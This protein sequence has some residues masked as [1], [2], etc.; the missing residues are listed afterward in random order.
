MLVDFY[1]NQTMADELTNC[2]GLSPVLVA[3]RTCFILV[4]A[5]LIIAGNILSIAV[6]R[7]VNNLADSTKVLMTALAASD[8][9][10]GLLVLFTAAASAQ[11]GWTFGTLAC[12]WPLIA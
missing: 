7:R 1:Q 11:D 8:L 6:T 4:L 9:L 10:V 3:L 2:L 5:L 12:S